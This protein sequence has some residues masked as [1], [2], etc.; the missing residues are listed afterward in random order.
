MYGKGCNFNVLENPQFIGLYK[1]AEG[2]DQ[3]EVLIEK[4]PYGKFITENGDKWQFIEKY[5][6]RNYRKFE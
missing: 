5:W 3:A 1:M 4:L 2:N 6:N